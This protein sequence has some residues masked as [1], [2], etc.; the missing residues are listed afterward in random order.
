M[1]ELFNREDVES[2]EV[3][4]AVKLADR[5]SECTSFQELCK[6][7][8]ADAALGH[9]YLGPGPL[10]LFEDE[11]DSDRLANLFLVAQIFPQQ[12]EGQRVVEDE[13]AS[14]SA[15]DE[16]S[17]F[18]LAI[19]RFIRPSELE[20]G[21]WEQVYCYLWDYSAKLSHELYTQANTVTTDNPQGCPRIRSITRLGMG[22]NTFSQSTT[23]GGAW[24]ADYSIDIGETLG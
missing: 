14:A 4:W 1:A 24:L 19:R 20:D 7:Y 17:T 8:S 5:L 9:I 15:P 2:C 10:P 16:A 18:A 22:F 21:N 13:T 6:E 3:G 23:E 12:E 11:F